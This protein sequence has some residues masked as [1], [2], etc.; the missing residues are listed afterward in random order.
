[1]DV[2]KNH[3]EDLSQGGTPVNGTFTGSGIIGKLDILLA[4]ENALQDT[5]SLVPSQ[6]KLRAILNFAKPSTFYLSC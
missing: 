3:R 6:I 5:A 1:M 2:L 4:G